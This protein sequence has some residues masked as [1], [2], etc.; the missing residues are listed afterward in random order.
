M[1]EISEVYEK[2]YA[3]TPKED[4]LIGLFNSYVRRGE[5]QKQ[6][7]T[8]MKL[9]KQYSNDKYLFWSIMSS[10]LQVFP[11]YINCFQPHFFF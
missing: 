6:S 3:K 7:Q 8:A 1:E 2:A 11:T 5:I 9:W 10:A 4:I